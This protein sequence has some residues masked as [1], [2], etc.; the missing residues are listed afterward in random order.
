MTYARST[1]N[2]LGEWVGFGR[3]FD[4]NTGPWTLERVTSTVTEETLKEYSKPADSEWAGFPSPSPLLGS[5][6]A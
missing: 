6:S 3:H 5:R 1:C 2:R 4:L